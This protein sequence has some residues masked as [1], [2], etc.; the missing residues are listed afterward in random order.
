ML[1]RSTQE[2]KLQSIWSYKNG[3]LVGCMQGLSLFPGVSRFAITITTLQWL[4]YS[5]R[6]AFAISF[7]LQWPLIVAGSIKGYAALQ[8]Q[9]VLDT[10]WS[11]PFCLI[12]L[13]S[14]VIAFVIFCL[15][16][17]MIDKNMLWKFS[18]YM[19][20]PITIALTI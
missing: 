6:T 20:I 11:L 2:K 18:Y 17:K 5:S 19:I 9:V 12:V 13:L 7:L 16:G 10:I 8:D 15:V 14:S 1:F 4:G 3:C